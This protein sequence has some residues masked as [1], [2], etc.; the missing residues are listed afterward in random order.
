MSLA[1]ALSILFIFSK[2]QLLVLLIFVTVFFVSISFV[3]ALIF[4]ISFLLLILGFLCFL[5]LGWCGCRVVYLAGFEDG[6]GFAVLSGSLQ[7]HV[8]L[9][10]PVEHPEEVVVGT[11]H[12]HTRGRGREGGKEAGLVR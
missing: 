3:S 4:M 6:P 5:S 7:G 2:N 9:G 10:V 12:D 11:G 1:K 8:P